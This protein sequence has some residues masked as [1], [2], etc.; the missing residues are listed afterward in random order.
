MSLA[1]DSARAR[2]ASAPNA[3]RRP[4]MTE[5]DAPGGPR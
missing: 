3:P 1:P 4:A 5:F 2:R